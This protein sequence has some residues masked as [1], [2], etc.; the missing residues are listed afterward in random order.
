[1]AERMLRELCITKECSTSL[2]PPELSWLPRKLE[3]LLPG[4]AIKTQSCY[5]YLPIGRTPVTIRSSIL[6]TCLHQSRLKRDYLCLLV[7]RYSTSRHRI[8]DTPGLANVL[9]N[10]VVRRHGLPDAIVLQGSVVTSKFWSPQYYFQA[11]L[12]YHPH[13][14]YQED[15]DLHSTIHISWM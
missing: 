9:V 13:A 14:A 3:N 12:S 4:N 10:L 2:K 7:R 6:L 5:Q 11:R 1:M 8:I 15:C